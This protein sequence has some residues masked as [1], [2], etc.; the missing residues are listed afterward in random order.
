[1][2]SKA[3]V[4]CSWGLLLSGDI[5]VT[6]FFSYV[7]FNWVEEGG[8]VVVEDRWPGG[9]VCI[10]LGHLW[11][12]A[13]VV[14]VFNWVSLGLSS[15]FFGGDDWLRGCFFVMSAIVSVIL[16]VWRCYFLIL[17]WRV[18]FHRCDCLLSQPCFWW[19]A[20]ALYSC[21]VGIRCWGFLWRIC[22]RVYCFPKAQARRN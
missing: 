2:A 22:P 8:E 4:F 9:A 20:W 15:G 6:V 13:D 21:V 10:F 12:S 5:S 19:G 7:F 1:M 16:I 18:S 14:D 3:F 11:R 17:L